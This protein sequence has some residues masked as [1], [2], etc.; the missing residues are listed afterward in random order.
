MKQFL[1][2]CNAAV[3]FARSTCSNM[4]PPTG[5]TKARCAR[6]VTNLLSTAM[7]SASSHGQWL[8][9]LPLYCI[10][11]IRL[12]VTPEMFFYFSFYY[13]KCFTILASLQYGDGEG[14]KWLTFLSAFLSLLLAWSRQKSPGATLE[15]STLWSPLEFSSVWR[16]PM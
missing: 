9:F 11:L 13:L 7:P 1:D 15:R 5:V 3:L 14:K 2:V 4:I 6:T 10:F 8:W 16:R 12:A